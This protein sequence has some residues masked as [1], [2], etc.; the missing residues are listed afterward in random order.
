MENDIL[1]IANE[2]Q[3]NAKAE[4]Q[5]VIDYD[6][7]I[8]KIME[9]S[10]NEEMRKLLIS[11]LREIIADELNHNSKLQNFYIILTEIEPNKN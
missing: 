4:A 11:G 6:N 7:T 10:L 5:A 9:S 3:S 2:M 8:K 1:E